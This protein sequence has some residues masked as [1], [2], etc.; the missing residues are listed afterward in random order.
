MDPM[1]QDIWVVPHLRVRGKYSTRD[2]G[3]EIFL[4]STFEHWLVGKK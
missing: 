4:T 1:P 3:I 2:R